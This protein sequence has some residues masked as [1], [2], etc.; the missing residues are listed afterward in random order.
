MPHP[1]KVFTIYAREDAQYLEELRGQLRPLEIAGRIKVWSDREINPGVD[2]EKEIVQNLDTADIILILVSAAYYS[3]V[4]IHEK[5]IK[6]ALTRHESGEAKVLPIIVR[7]CAFGDDPV[8]SR[9]QVLPTDGKP[10]TDRRHW[11]ERDEAWLDVVTGVKRTLDI[12]R[13]A[14]TGHIP[15]PPNIEPKV[16]P[17]SS[18]VKPPP[19]AWRPIALWVLGVIA[20]VVSLFFGY[21]YLFKATE[22]EKAY[23]KAETPTIQRGKIPLGKR[24]TFDFVISNVG[25]TTAVVND[26][27]AA[28]NYVKILDTAA[29]EIA[30]NGSKT[31]RAEWTGE[32]EFGARRC[33]IVVG[34]SNVV[35]RVRISVQAEVV[36]ADTT[37]GTG[38][39]KP[40]DSDGDNSGSTPPTKARLIV[41]GAS[42]IDFGEIKQNDQKTR[43]F[44]VRNSSAIKAT[45]HSATSSCAAVK[46]VKSGGPNTILAN[47]LGSYNVVWSANELGQQQCTLTISGSN[48]EGPVRIVVK[49]NVIKDKGGEGS[50]TLVLKTIRCLT[51]GIGGIKVWFYDSD[52]KKYEKI[53]VSGEDDVEFSIPPT[54]SGKIIEVNYKRGTKEDHRD[55]VLSPSAPFEV[56]LGIRK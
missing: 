45:V 25:K 42:V 28:C 16:N 52:G 39:V 3:S 1:Y 32:A 44:M 43:S 21:N 34:G 30:A 29:A 47:D 6:Y 31:Y 7:S 14:E 20:T 56:P 36:K 41:E 19:T 53:S 27:S 8:I 51:H 38:T 17:P 2:W 10:V 35:G 48:L 15:A 18:T 22:P 4:Y 11:P 55:E 49:A 12:L 46:V 13:S 23:L 37:Q 9:L 50:S 26:I 40:T 5:E 24:D 33:E 54:M